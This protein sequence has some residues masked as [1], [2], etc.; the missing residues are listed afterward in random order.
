MFNSIKQGGTLRIGKINSIH[1]SGYKNGILGN[2]LAGKKTIERYFFIG[3][4][5][6]YVLYNSTIQ[7]GFIGPESIFTD[8][9]EDWVLHAKL[10][11]SA[12]WEKISLNYSLFLNSSENERAQMHIYGR[13]GAALRF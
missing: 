4:A 11:F 12:H 2:N 7:G 3:P 8:T 6:E 9:K 13:F 1:K 5:L 10:G